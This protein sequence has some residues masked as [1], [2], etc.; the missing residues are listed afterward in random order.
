MN[1]YFASIDVE[2]CGRFAQFEYINSDECMRRAIAL[3]DKL[4]ALDA[5]DRP[6]LETQP[7]IMT[8]SPLRISLGGG[9]TDLPSYYQEHSG[10]V[11][12]AA[13]DQVCLYL[14]IHPRFTPRM[15]LKYSQMEEVERID[16]IKHPLIRETLRPL[17]WDDLRLEITSMADIPAG[18]GLG[19]SGSFTTALL[20]ALHAQKKHLTNPARARRAGVQD[21]DGFRSESRW[22]SKTSI[23]RP[24][25]GSPAFASCPTARSRPGR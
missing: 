1:D 7:V 14:L 23:S 2:L 9:G 25:A 21:R 18:T 16:D 3:A 13:I 6:K 5:T 19:S 22:A 17:E 15:L 8:R 24:S 10:F 11:V 4:N 12:S 20:K